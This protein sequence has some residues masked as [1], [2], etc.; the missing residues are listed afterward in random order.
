[1]DKIV[2][3]LGIDE[4]YTRPVKK[5]KAY[6]RVKD[7]IPPLE[8]YNFMADLLMLPNDGGYKY[9]LVI[10]D[11]WSDEFDIEALKTKKPTEV[12]NAMKTIFGRQHLNKPYAT[13]ATDGGSEFKSV[14]AK[15]LYN[16][17]IYHKV[18]RTGRHTQMGNVES[19]NRSLARLFN[20]YMNKI[21]EETGRVYRG[22]RDVLPQVRQLLNAH[23]KKPSK[24]PYKHKYKAPS[25]NRTPK[26]KVGDIVY[27]QLDKPQDALG[28]TQN[29]ENFREGDYRFDRVPRKVKAVYL[30]GGEVPFR[31]SVT[32]IKNV[33]YTEKQLRKADPKEKQEKFIVKEIVGK[34]TR[35][36]KVE[37]KIWWKGYLKK[38]ATWEK[39]SELMKDVPELIKE[40][41]S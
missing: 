27:V 19:L 17:S 2:K 15:Y 30:Y 6:T 32:G 38:N 5:P 11:L 26:F 36:K 34:R 25:F 8:D 31:Y 35:K 9:L 40:Y 16:E 12:L 33:S 4:R 14:F 10:V 39:R 18:A 37:Y 13:L 28:R 1:M 20:G 7:N 23:R 24:D 3:Q 41:E 22:W 29:T 21:E